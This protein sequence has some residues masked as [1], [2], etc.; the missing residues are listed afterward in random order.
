MASS[1]PSEAA[2]ARAL[3]P[4]CTAAACSC[5]REQLCHILLL[6]QA[7]YQAQMLTERQSALGMFMLKPIFLLTATARPTALQAA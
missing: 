5:G 2:H 7:L 4:L 1:R 3:T 6:Y